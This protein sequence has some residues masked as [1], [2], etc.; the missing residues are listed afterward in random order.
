MGVAILP[1]KTIFSSSISILPLGV[2]I[3]LS[4]SLRSHLCDVLPLGNPARDVRY[5]RTAI[6]EP[7]WLTF[8]HFYEF[9]P[10]LT[11]KK[12]LEI[13]LPGCVVQMQNTFGCYYAVYLFREMS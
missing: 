12:V 6:G 8:L 2:E 9:I 3:L 5:G 11:G 4:S 10:S 13:V 1:T 7:F